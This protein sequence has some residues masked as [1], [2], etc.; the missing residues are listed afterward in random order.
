MAHTLIRMFN[1]IDQAQLAR[2]ALLAGG[3]DIDDVRLDASEDEA[4][5]VAGNFLLPREDTPRGRAIGADTSAEPP[6][7]RPETSTNSQAVTQGQYILTVEAGDDGA[8][9]RAAEIV[10]R[11]GAVDPDRDSR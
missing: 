3:F 11:Y 4:G 8:L 9:D 5:T 7:R 1:R 10:R 2:E 6:A